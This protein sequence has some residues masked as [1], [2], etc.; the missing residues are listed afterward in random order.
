[1]AMTAELRE[2]PDILVLMDLSS[3]NFDDGSR[4]ARGFL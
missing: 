2:N 4:S 1:V 3:P